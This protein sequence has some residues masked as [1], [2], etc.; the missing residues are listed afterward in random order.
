MEPILC[1]L[2]FGTTH[3]PVCTRC[4]A[5]TS[6]VL[7]KV[8]QF[9]P[10][11]AMAFVVASLSRIGVGLLPE[12]G[13]GVAGPAVAG[14]LGVLVAIQGMASQAIPKRL[15]AGLLTS[16]IL[17]AGYLVELL[18]AAGSLEAIDPAAL[19]EPLAIYGGGMLAGIVVLWPVSVLVA[20]G[21]P[22]VNINEWTERIPY[23]RV[24]QSVRI[25]LH[26]VVIA[27]IVA[28]VAALLV[29]AVVLLTAYL[30]L[31]FVWKLLEA[32]LYEEFGIGMDPEEKARRKKAR[33][34]QEAAEARAEAERQQRAAEMQGRTA[35]EHRG[36]HGEYLGYTTEDGQHRG[37]HGE[38]LGYTT[39]GGEHRGEHGEYQGYTT[40]DGE[41]R[42]EHGEFLGY[43]KEK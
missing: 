6:S 1:E 43:K 20:T 41:L 16:G 19:G 12:P 32:F 18:V 27:G 40:E 36:K 10:P 38:Y 39:E 42:G 3:E 15:L 30:G 34:Q 9:L 29:V 35:G 22:F 14:G 31:L 2:C 37:K 21:P 5:D 23:P 7:Y 13:L 8:G 25:G 11:I 24:R 4:R 26:G 28:L 33:K 17:L